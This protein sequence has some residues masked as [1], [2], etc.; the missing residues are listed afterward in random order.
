MD[1]KLKPCPFCG[2]K[3]QL[4]LIEVDEPV[5][6][7][8]LYYTVYCTNCKISIGAYHISKLPQFC[9]SEVKEAQTQAIEAW[10]RRVE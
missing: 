4:H 8:D 7:F 1:I 6:F 9:E 5:T 3:A 2:G 10:N